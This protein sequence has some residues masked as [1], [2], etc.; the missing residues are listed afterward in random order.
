MTR[1][2]L[3]ESPEYW[4]TDACANLWREATRYLQENNLDWSDLEDLG[5]PK[6]TVKM[7][8]DG[9]LEP[10]PEYYDVACRLGYQP[11]LELRK[12]K[13]VP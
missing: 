2:E 1:Q 12:N 6:K 10:G 9:D 8:R 4:L 13:E 11:V 3:M 7:L 5:I